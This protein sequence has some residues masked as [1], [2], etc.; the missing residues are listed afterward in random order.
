MIV[1]FLINVLEIGK[2]H[3]LWSPSSAQHSLNLEWKVNCVDESIVAGYNISYCLIADINTTEC[4]HETL[5]SQTILLFE[6]EE[7]TLTHLS[8]LKSW[9]FYKISVALLSHSRLGPDSDFIVVRTAESGKLIK[10]SFVVMDCL[11]YNMFVCSTKSSN[12]SES[13]GSNK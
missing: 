6:D 3:S 5:K 1:I 2:V 8:N 7:V 13:I 9:S 10:T 12:E 4:D 11:K